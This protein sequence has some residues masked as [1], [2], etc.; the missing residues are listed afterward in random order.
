MDR[1]FNHNRQ[2]ASSDGRRRQICLPET[3]I[4]LRDFGK[5][6]S[7]KIS[8]MLP[9]L[10]LNDWVVLRSLPGCCEQA[11]HV[12]Y[13]PSDDMLS[14]E[15]VPVNVLV[16]LQD[17]TTLEVWPES[18]RLISSMVKSE[19][20]G[21]D[22]CFSQTRLSLSRGDVLLFRGDL[23]HAGSAYDDNNVRLHCYMDMSVRIPN[24]TWLVDKKA[25]QHVR[26]AI[27]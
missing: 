8:D 25:P 13:D 21:K 22:D 4:A 9:H 24:R 3:S 14:T 16:A 11:P 26:D 10:K 1:I 15:T 12:D 23:V 27:K 17:S 7:A 19:K 18:H 20:L 5:N 6:I 2:R